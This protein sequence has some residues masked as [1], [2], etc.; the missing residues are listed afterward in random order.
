MGTAILSKRGCFEN[1]TIRHVDLFFSQ[2]KKKTTK[3]QQ[4]DYFRWVVL[5]LLPKTN[6]DDA[7]TFSS[8]ILLI[9]K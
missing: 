1:Y 4:E 8:S 7:L 9:G 2:V 3:T 6:L 5:A